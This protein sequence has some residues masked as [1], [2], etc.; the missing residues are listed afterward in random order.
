MSDLSLNPVGDTLTLY[1]QIDD[2]LRSKTD[3]LIERM[4]T[5]AA[6]SKDVS[7]LENTVQNIMSQI[8]GDS[9][10]VEELA[11]N[12]GIEVT[13]D[14][15]GIYS[16]DLEGSKWQAYIDK[17]YDA[18]KLSTRKY[19]FEGKK[20]IELFQK[21]LEQQ[22]SLLKNETSE[23]MLLI[24]PLLNL[25]ELF[26]NMAKKCVELDEKLKEKANNIR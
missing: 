9:K 17:L 3:K 4:H 25:I 6:Q 5:I 2:H 10:D 24:Q 13:S 22:K 15:K 7:E 19:K 16:I 14:K 20:E 23:P 26:A 12:F 8:S 21:E 1:G 11:N 18:G